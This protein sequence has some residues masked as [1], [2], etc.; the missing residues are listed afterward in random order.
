MTGWGLL[1]LAG[2]LECGWPIALK[3]SHP[4][5]SLRPTLTLIALAS[6][7]I[8]MLNIAPKTLPVGSAYAVR[9]GIREAGT[10][11]IGIILLGESA[12]ALRLVSIGRISRGVVGMRLGESAA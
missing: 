1:I 2:L 3:A 6:A 12:A 11:I 9:T 8:I 7:S 4:M 10:A 5:T